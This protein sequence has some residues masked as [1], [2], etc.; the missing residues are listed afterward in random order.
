MYTIQPSA[1]EVLASCFALGAKHVGN[2]V[3]VLFGVFA[4]TPV[5]LEGECICG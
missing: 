2:S 4:E 1:C 5:F 3:L